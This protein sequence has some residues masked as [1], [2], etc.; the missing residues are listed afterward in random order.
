MDIARVRRHTHRFTTECS[1]SFLILPVGIL[2]E[3]IKRKHRKTNKC[4][5]KTEKFAVGKNWV[6]LVYIALSI[7]IAA[8]VYWFRVQQFRLVQYYA[9]PTVKQA[10]RLNERAAIVCLAHW[11]AR[12]SD[13]DIVTWLVVGLEGR[14]VTHTA[15]GWLGSSRTT[16]WVNPEYL[17][18]L[19][20]AKCSQMYPR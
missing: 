10:G 16:Y 14:P 20:W 11:M 2:V 4:I 15:R 3:Y 8:H 13:V 1:S 12:G 17:D 9:P 6:V 19:L 18:S 5:I 7:D